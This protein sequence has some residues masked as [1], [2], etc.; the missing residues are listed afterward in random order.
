MRIAD[1][2]EHHLAAL[3][4]KLPVSEFLFGIH[5]ALLSSP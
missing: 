4:P 5:T 2:G 1:I 3:S